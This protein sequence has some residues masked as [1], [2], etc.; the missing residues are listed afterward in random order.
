[1]PNVQIPENSVGKLMIPV[2]G[3]KP[4]NLQ[5]TYTQSRSGNRVHNAIDI[6]APG[7]APVVAV[8]DGEIVKFSTVNSAASQFIN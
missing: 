6:M 8:A 2:V 7:G 5:D 1:V 3:I 4:E